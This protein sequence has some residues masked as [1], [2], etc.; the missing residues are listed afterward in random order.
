MGKIM[1]SCPVKII[2]GLIFKDQKIFEKATAFLSKNLGPI[3]LES[4]PFLFKFTNYYNDEMGTGLK[5]KFLS[6]KKLEKSEDIY[7]VKI[8]TN[9][10][11]EKFS[12]SGKR[13]V[14]IDPGY[15]T[16]SKLV[17]LTTK[18]YSH[19]IH[20]RNGIHAE[21]TLCFKDKAYQPLE[22]TYPDYKTEGY[23][24]FFNHVRGIYI[25]D[26]EEVE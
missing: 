11:E 23:R 26:L 2:T 5:R 12:V 21:I 20:L 7:K 24:E 9:K 22:W 16:L 15:L 17:L 25:K 8:F 14:N 3:D 4:A 6:F 10:L 18:D 19:R 1:S 13:K